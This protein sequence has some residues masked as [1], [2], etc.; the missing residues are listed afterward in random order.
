MNVIIR[1]LNSFCVGLITFSKYLIIRLPFCKST[2]APTEWPLLEQGF[3]LTTP[4]Q[5]IIRVFQ[6]FHHLTAIST[7]QSKY[8]LHPT[9]APQEHPQEELQLP[10]EGPQLQ[11]GDQDGLQWGPQPGHLDLFQQPWGDLHGGLSRHQQ[12]PAQDPSWP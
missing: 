1:N 9:A 4:D 8:H 6:R 7:A 12:V 2:A 11:A 3:D 5:W 10:Q